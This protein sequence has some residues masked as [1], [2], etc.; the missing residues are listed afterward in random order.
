MNYATIEAF[1]SFATDSCEIFINLWKFGYSFFCFLPCFFQ[2]SKSSKENPTILLYFLFFQPWTDNCKPWTLTI[3]RL[4]LS[5]EVCIVHLA[6]AICRRGFRCQ[7][8]AWM[9]KT[10]VKDNSHQ[11]WWLKPNITTYCACQQ[12]NSIYSVE[13]WLMIEE[14]GTRVRIFRNKNYSLFVIA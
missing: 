11:F 6:S 2:T 4:I 3:N 10:W 8:S 5:Y 13:I 9:W 14:Q 7:T 12:I 1:L